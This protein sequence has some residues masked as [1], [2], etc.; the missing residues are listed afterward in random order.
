MLQRRLEW[1]YLQNAAPGFISHARLCHI[2]NPVEQLLFNVRPEHVEEITILDEGRE[3]LHVGAWIDD[4]GERKTGG[5]K[6][7]LLNQFQGL[8]LS[9]AFFSVRFDDQPM[10]FWRGDR[11]GYVELRVHFGKG[12][13][14]EAKVFAV[15]RVE[16][17]WPL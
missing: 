7:A 9:G 8:Y 14:G 5:Q 3:V 12:F 2:K 13:V 6:M 10:T 4:D 16:A 17:G 1:I 15:S 11:L